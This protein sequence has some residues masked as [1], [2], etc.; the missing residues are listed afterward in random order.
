MEAMKTKMTKEEAIARIKRMEWVKSEMRRCI[1]LGL[2]V[3]AVKEK[4]IQLCSFNS[5]K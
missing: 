5:A 2:P 1:A 4:G 3:S